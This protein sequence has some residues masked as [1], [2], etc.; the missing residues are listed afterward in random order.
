[1]QSRKKIAKAEG[2][3]KLLAWAKGAKQAASILA[4]AGTQQK[5][6]AIS[7]MAEK[8]DIKKAEIVKANQEDQGSARESGLRP[9]LIERLVFDERR[10]D[11]RIKALHEIA[12][13]P[14]PIGCATEVIRRPSG[15]EVKKV[16][17]PIGVVGMI[18]ESRPHVTVNA[19]A[20]CLKSGNAVLLKGGSETITTNTLLGRLWQEALRETGLPEACIQVIETTERSAVVTMLSLDQ[21]ID[22]LIPRGG[23]ELVEMIR[24]NSK[25]PI[26]KHYQGICHVFIDREVQ[27]DMAIRVSLDSKILMPEV[28]NAME[29]LLLDEG[30]APRLLPKI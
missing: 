28:C 11:S 21:F 13:L 8:L 5:N 22:V 29:T 20:L 17:V 1:M 9:V 2:A 10:I 18:Y 26:I 3:G 25:I 15:L 19:G 6:H 27:E 30:V 23:K 24:E 12:L 4:K 14:D 7:L 16:R